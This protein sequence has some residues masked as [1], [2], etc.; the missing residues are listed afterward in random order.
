MVWVFSTLSTVIYI[1][2]QYFYFFLYVSAHDCWLHNLWGCSLL[3]FL[4]RCSLI[5]LII[6]LIAFWT[7][8]STYSWKTGTQIDR[9]IDYY[10][11]KCSIYLFFPSKSAFLLPQHSMCP[12][13]SILLCRCLLVFIFPFIIF[14]LFPV[15]PFSAAL[16]FHLHGLQIAK[17]PTIFFASSSASSLFCTLFSSTSRLFWS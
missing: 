16:F 5:L 11:P 8:S 14:L 6:S 15:R 10:V 13:F 7:S 2:F 12:S 9:W 4:S 1:S 3:S 17:K